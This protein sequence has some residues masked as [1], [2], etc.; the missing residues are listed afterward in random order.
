MKNDSIFIYC[1]AS[2][3]KIYQI[4][5]IGSLLFKNNKEHLHLSTEAQTKLIQIREINNIRAEIKGVILAL[6]SCQNEKHVVLYT[7]CQTLSQL[8][9]RRPH[10]EKTNYNQ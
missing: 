3:S 9:R 4:A 7:D 6:Q 10:L 2:F 1:D 8:I 5:I